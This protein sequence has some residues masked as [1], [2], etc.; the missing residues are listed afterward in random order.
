MGFIRNSGSSKGT[1]GNWDSPLYSLHPLLTLV[2]RS[3]HIG[4][5]IKQTVQKLLL[6]P[7]G[8]CIA[9]VGEHWASNTA[10]LQYERNL[11]V[12][13]AVATTIDSFVEHDYWYIV[14]RRD[15]ARTAVSQYLTMQSCTKIIIVIVERP[16]VGYG[17]TS[18]STHFSLLRRRRYHIQCESKK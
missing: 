3:S 5:A 8:S 9:A 6:T 14:L 18:H 17:L 12:A 10:R 1:A 11:F 4:C 2:T 13:E 7:R 15:F 16:R